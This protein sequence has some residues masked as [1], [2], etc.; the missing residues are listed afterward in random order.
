[1]LVA[2][3]CGLVLLT[4][5]V[6]GRA[7]SFDF[8]N[9]DDN[10]YVYENPAV[11]D[12]LSARGLGWAFTTYWQLNWHPLTWIS[13]MTDAQ[14]TRWAESHDVG[15][16]SERAGIYHLTNILLHL[17]SVVILFFLLNMMTGRMWPSAFVAALFGVHPM[18]VESVAW[19]AERKDVLSTLFWLL[20]LLAYARYARRPGVLRYL[21]VVGLFAL[22]LMSKPMVVTLPL[23]LLLMDLWPLGRVQGIGDRG[24]GTGSGP[25]RETTPA[26]S[27]IVEKLPLLAMSAAS[28]VVTVIAQHSGRGIVPFDIMPFGVRAANASVSGV[29]YVLKMLW[30]VKLACMYPHPMDTIPTWMVPTSAVALAAVTFLAIR[31]AKSRPY[32]TAGWL[33]YLVTLVPV[34]GLVQVGR[35]Q[36]ADRYSYIPLTGLFILIAW[37]VPELTR[38]RRAVAGLAVVIVAASAVACYVQVGYWTD[39][40]TLMTHATRVTSRNFVAENNLGQALSERQDNAEALVHVRQALV[41]N[42]GYVDA[43]YN[44]GTLLVMRGEYDEAEAVLNRVVAANPAH[45]QA[46]N[47]LGRI[48]IMRHDIDGAIEHFRA[49][50]EA[51]PHNETAVT[52]LEQALALKQSLSR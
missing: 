15:I 42:P 25:T 12:G 46:H 28:C 43:L 34:C 16:G 39:S 32:V 40:I 14:I 33:W 13:L 26:A 9:L 19:V 36:M 11:T 49:A 37:A 44:L 48:R 18:H 2:V 47:N 3:V 38:L 30:P 24:Q 6:F 35:Q 52:N 27:L 45:V 8:I 22:G 7:P 41:Y 50:A 5:L 29:E 23:V 4:A 51:D 21:P 17:A 10:V 20:T 1:M 31:A